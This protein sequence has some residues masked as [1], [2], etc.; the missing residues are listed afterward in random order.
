LLCLSF[1][2]TLT[3]PQRRAEIYEEALDA[4]LKKWD[5]SRSIK[6]D[7]IYYGMTAGRKRQMLARIATKSFQMNE[8]FIP[9]T[10]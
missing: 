9:Q 10:N 7:R 4:L 2:E 6:R 5:A 8:Y 1:E 3:F